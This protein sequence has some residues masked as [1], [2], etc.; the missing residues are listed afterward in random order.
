MLNTGSSLINLFLFLIQS[1]YLNKRNL[2][3][4][5]YPFLLSKNQNLSYNKKEDFKFY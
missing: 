2:D 4:Y 1:F 5:K 3:C